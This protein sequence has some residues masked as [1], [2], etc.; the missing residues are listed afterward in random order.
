MFIW[1]WFGRN[2]STTAAPSQPRQSWTESKKETNKQNKKKRKEKKY[3][4]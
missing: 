2:N 4:K 3:D 1:E